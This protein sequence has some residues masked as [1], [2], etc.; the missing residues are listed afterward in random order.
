M[1]NCSTRPIPEEPDLDTLN[2]PEEQRHFYVICVMFN[3]S[4]SRSR[5]KLYLNFKRQ[6]EKMGV[7]LITIECTY[8][9]SP[10]TLT[11]QNY[12]PHN[13]QVNT[14]NAFFQKER[15][16]NLALTKLPLDAKY[17][18]WC[19]CEVEFLNPNWVNDTIKALNI[20]KIVQM[21]ESVTIL[22]EN[23]EEIKRERSFSAR[24]F[25]KIE[26]DKKD[27]EECVE[28]S[29]YCWGFRVDIL[30]E[31]GGL[32]DLSPIGNCDTIMAYCLAK[33]TDEYVP[34]TLTDHFKDTIKDWQKK[35][36][37]AFSTG[38]G[39]IPGEIRKHWSALR[40]D[41]KVY[42]RWDILQTN[43]YD[44]S[45]DLYSGENGIYYLD[46]S[47]IQLKNDLKTMFVAAN[48]EMIE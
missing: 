47:N 41:K 10:F 12:E 31:I 25:D 7:K 45:R 35:A 2:Y 26:M 38:I 34:N 32:Y 19:D 20:F 24:L 27:F 48:G 46:P 15:L 18:V 11:R 28:Y 33:R 8:E 6:L 21:F 14:Q 42:D 29:G 37:A 13:I 9:N 17:V 22:G 44:P 3:P 39:F 36:S 4:R 16:I 23:N 40:N 5:I 30:K 43:G 1:G